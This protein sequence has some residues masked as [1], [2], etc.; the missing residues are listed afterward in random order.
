MRL[1]R[2]A[3]T[4]FQRPVSHRIG[5]AHLA[6]DP[7]FRSPRNLVCAGSLIMGGC[8]R[9]S[10]IAASPRFPLGRVIARL[11]W[12]R[13]H[14]LPPFGRTV[15]RA[16]RI[17]VSGQALYTVRRVLPTDRFRVSVA[18]SESRERKGVAHAGCSLRGASQNTSGKNLSNLETVLGKASRTISL[19]TLIDIFGT[20]G[21]PRDRVVRSGFSGEKVGRVPQTAS[22]I[23][24]MLVSG[25]RPRFAE[26]D[27]ARSVFDFTLEQSNLGRSQVEQFVDAGVDVGFGV[28]ELLGERLDGGTLLGE[29]GFP[30]VGGL[31]FLERVCL[32]L[33]TGLQ[34]VAESL[35][36]ACFGC[37][38]LNKVANPQHAP[39]SVLM[40]HPSR[41]EVN[42]LAGRRLESTTE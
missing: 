13:L 1:Y 29:V 8:R 18:G 12:G 19:G 4:S 25:T 34:G 35:A 30:L 9:A 24:L 2:H 33:E 11:S 20:V 36:N 27:S 7:R 5:L 17:V 32:E 14:A 26:S 39:L 21:E 6:P 22:R 37:D 41:P 23:P 31:W 10:A 3:S 16:G 40:L 15:H 42:H 38:R 28:G